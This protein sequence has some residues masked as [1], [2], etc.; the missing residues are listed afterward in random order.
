MKPIRRHIGKSVSFY[1]L[2]SEVLFDRP[3]IQS[4]A[5]WDFLLLFLHRLPFSLLRIGK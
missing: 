3:K 4:P 1:K 5:W 2:T